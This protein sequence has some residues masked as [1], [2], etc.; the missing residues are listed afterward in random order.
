MDTV[1][2]GK[3]GM[4]R[5]SSIEIYTLPSVKLDSQWKFT[6]WCRELKS[7]AL[8]Q[9]RGVGCGGRWKGGARERGDTYTYSWFML[10]IAEANTIL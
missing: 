1:G 8:W 6:V 4:N 3:D 7:G 10:Y 5:E 2:E 9:P